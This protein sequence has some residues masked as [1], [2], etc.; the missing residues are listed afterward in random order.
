[1]GYRFKVWDCYRPQRAVDYMN[2]WMLNDDEKMKREFYPY[3][4]KRYLY[5]RGYVAKRSGHSR[6]STLDITLVRY[7]PGE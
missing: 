1:M 7:N 6:G 3:E 2:E 4:D 5:E